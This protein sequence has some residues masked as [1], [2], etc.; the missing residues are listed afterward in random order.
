MVL[1]IVI[2]VHLTAYFVQVIQN[3]LYA[4]MNF[5]EHRQRMD[6]IV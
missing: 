6:Q 4:K 2:V 5:I 1:P 3:V